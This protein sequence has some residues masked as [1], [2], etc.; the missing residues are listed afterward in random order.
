MRS[1]AAEDR[2]AERAKTECQRKRL[3]KGWLS[4][5][6]TVTVGKLSKVSLTLSGALFVFFS[7]PDVLCLGSLISRQMVMDD[8]NCCH[9]VAIVEHELVQMDCRDRHNTECTANGF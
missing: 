9:A 3:R 6:G 1:V 4:R 5:A 7:C 2:G 8:R